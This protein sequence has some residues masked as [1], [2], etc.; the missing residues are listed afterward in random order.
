MLI[1]FVIVNLTNAVDFDSHLRMRSVWDSSE[2]ACAIYEYEIEKA[3]QLHEIFLF[4]GG[5]STSEEADESVLSNLSTLP[6][7]CKHCR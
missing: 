2:N 1:L 4:K 6:D 3:E 5:S 7:Q